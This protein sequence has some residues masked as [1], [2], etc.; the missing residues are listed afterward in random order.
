MKAQHAS[1]FQGLLARLEGL[2]GMALD[3]DL[4]RQALAHRSYVNENPGDLPG[5]NER[6]EFLGDAVL[7]LVVTHQLYLT[8][9]HG[10]EGELSRKKALLVSEASLAGYAVDLGVDQALLV[11]RGERA[12]GGSRKRSLLA[13]AMEA[14]IG[15]LYLAGG[16]EAARRLILHYMSVKEKTLEGQWLTDAKT[17]LQE[18]L[19]AAQRGPASYRVVAEEGPDHAK[20]FRVEV[21]LD[22]KPLGQGAGSSK[23]EAEQEAASSALRRLEAL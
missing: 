22:G 23:K 14:V 4:V 5:S 20:T 18:M 8:V 1:A 13:D 15:A 12:S 17:R 6:M 10:D 21:W 19:Q 7:G 16:L 2:A 11:G 3:R 9:P